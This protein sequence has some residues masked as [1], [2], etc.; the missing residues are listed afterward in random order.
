MTGAGDGRACPWC[1]AAAAPEDTVCSSCGATLAQR[2]SIGDLVIPG[3]TDVDPGL[4][5]AAD[6]PLHIPGASPSQGIAGG[7]VIAA[8][9]AGGPIGLAALGGLGAL[10]ATEYGAAGAASSGSSEGGIDPVQDLGRPSEAALRMLERLD[11]EGD[12]AADD[13]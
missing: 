1:S 9:I 6:R 13:R 10:A 3:V 8:A 12:P 4:R 2:E 7:T 5:A 11:G